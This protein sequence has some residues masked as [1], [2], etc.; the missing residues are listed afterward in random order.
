[1][2]LISVTKKGFSVINPKVD[3]KNIES[4]LTLFRIKAE[5]Q[6]GWTF[7]TTDDSVPNVRIDHYLDEYQNEVSVLVA[8]AIVRNVRKINFN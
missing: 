8:Y 7:L 2:I 5:E 4:E 3:K 6:L 1:M